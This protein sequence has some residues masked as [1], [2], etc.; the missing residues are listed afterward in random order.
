MSFS[1]AVFFVVHKAI[2]IQSSRPLLSCNGDNK[3]TLQH[4]NK[5]NIYSGVIN[6]SVL[7]ILQSYCVSVVLILGPLSRLCVS[8]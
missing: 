7:I 1:V 5:I 3:A 6:N 4:R 8:V 2:K